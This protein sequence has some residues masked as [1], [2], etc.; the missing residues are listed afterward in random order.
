MR[1]MNGDVVFV[2]V[3]ILKGKYDGERQKDS[4]NDVI[5]ISFT[6]GLKTFDQFHFSS[7]KSN[8]AGVLNI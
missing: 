8:G 2:V 3:V 7:F 6:F 1:R 5:N 4:Q